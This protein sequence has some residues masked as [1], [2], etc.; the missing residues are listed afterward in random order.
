[1]KY[2]S[3]MSEHGKMYRQMLATWKIDD[4]RG[5]EIIRAVNATAR[6]LEVIADHGLQA[7]GLSLPRLRLMLALY[8]EEQH[9]NHTGVSPSQLSDWQHISKNT[10][11]SLLESLEQDGLIE[12]ALH[13]EDKRK[14]NIRLTRAGKSLIAQTMPEHGKRLADV[15]GVLTTDEQNT[16]LKLLDKLRASLKEKL[17]KPA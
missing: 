16:L 10:V 3:T 14:F 5:I 8:A 4:P 7:R 11:S 9:G 15:V 2:P 1:M 6:M 17:A 12:R 13:P